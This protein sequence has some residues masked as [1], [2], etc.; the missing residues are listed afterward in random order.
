MDACT[1]LVAKQ[2]VSNRSLLDVQW[3]YRAILLP[4]S[5]AGRDKSEHIKALF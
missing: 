2:S 3:Q 4:Q 1:I 5:K